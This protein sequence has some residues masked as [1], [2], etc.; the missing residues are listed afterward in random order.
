MSVQ[1]SQDYKSQNETNPMPMRK[2]TIFKLVIIIIGSFTTYIC[3]SKSFVEST[4]PK[5]YCIILKV[6]I[7]DNDDGYVVIRAIDQVAGGR[8]TNISCTYFIKLYLSL[9]K[10]WFI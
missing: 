2:N 4:R 5:F 3:S 6:L 10:I 8:G 7:R 1:N 9:N